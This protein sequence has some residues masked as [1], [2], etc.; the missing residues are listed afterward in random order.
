[1][2]AGVEKPGRPAGRG[3][4][5]RLHMWA[6][7]FGCCIGWGCFIMPGTEFL[8]EAGPAGTAIAMALGAAVMVLI[9]VNY[10]YMLNRY[11]DNGGAFTYT[12]KLFG[13]DQGF[14]CAWYLWL[15][16]VALI[17]AN[18]AAFILI[19]RQV[20]GNALA[21]GFHYRFAG[22]D[23]YFGE[24]LA[25]MGI[26]VLFGVASLYAGRLERMLHTVLALLL[27]A[28][29]VACF[30][31]VLARGGASGPIPAFSAARS[32]GRGV[33]H[34]VAL[35]PWAFIGFE[36]VSHVAG[37]DGFPRKS[38]LR[39]MAGA[40]IA[41]GVCYVLMVYV[42]ALRQPA[43]YSDW[44]G[45]IA[46]LGTKTGLAAIPT[47]FVVDS[48]LGKAGLA[49]LCVTVLAALST[50]M[51]GF[52]RVLGRLTGA[53][54]EDGILPAWF[55]RR[56]RSGNPRNAL[57]L[58]VL[59]S[60]PVPFL[61]ATA[62]G[63]FAD[64]T[65]I[66]AAISYSYTSAT[67]F[68][69]AR[70]TGDRRHALT[71]AAGTA[72]SVLFAVFLLMPKSAASSVQL[73]EESYLILSIWSVLGFVYFRF[74]FER[75]ANHSMNRSIVVWMVLLFLIF[76]PALM[77]TQQATRDNAQEAID[78]IAQ[79]YSQELADQGAA[80][81]AGWDARD[82][83]FLAERMSGVER[84]L[85][86]TTL[87][88]TLMILL[89]LYLL[90]SIYAEMRRREAQMEAEKAA[91]VAR[92]K[93][94]STFLSNMSHD[95]RTPMNAIVGYTTLAK[96]E[97]DMPPRIGD[98]LT[99]IESSSQHLLALI[100]DV[101]EM[102]RIETGE[103]DLELSETDLVRTMGEI[104]DMFQTQMETKRIRYLVE[105]E[106]VKDRRVLCDKN[107]LNRVLLNLL[108]NAYKF[109]PEGG[110]VSVRLRQTGALADRGSYEVRVR[111]SGIGMSPEFAA[112]VFEAYEREKT[113]GK[114]QGTGLGMAITKSIVDLMGG[115]ITVNTE[116]GKGS[117][118]VVAVDFALAGEAAAEDAAEEVAP[119]T[120]AETP[121]VD[122]STKKLLLV[123]DNEINREIATLILEEMG[124]GLDMAENGKIAVEKVMASKPGDYDAILMDIQMPVMNGYEAA[125][126]IRALENPALASI[127]IAAMTA[128]A[129]AE[130]IQA[131]EEAGMNGHIAKP[132]D[133]DD[134]FETL[135]KILR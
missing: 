115:T 53:L 26:L 126:A 22:Y 58:I 64:I 40:V 60:L 86:G 14:L 75:D 111:D 127:P 73:P 25:T 50:S 39:I 43:P 78:R 32:P 66:G 96:K 116:Q 114:I 81:Q 132:I 12:K 65:T 52:Y 106:G 87:V 1:M 130:D 121:A 129:F 103:M 54:G 23:V 95:I 70:R 19:A 17:W 117:E 98:Y 2:K 72:V 61:G 102:S 133:I 62:I 74:A 122:F 92:D 9:A 135:K 113:A 82:A 16:Y 42:A 63:W 104:R 18:S 11:P 29:V 7:A 37:E 131:A 101:L 83:A 99:K 57:L 67:V 3:S 94:K 107:R 10:H 123:E 119:E 69:D 77:W 124:F 35:A 80:R 120:A 110:T 27:L 30:L 68:W 21:F 41:A 118:F 44:Q 79:A 28:G 4:D 8:P 56:N 97:P 55:A 31:L 34:L 6:L 84:T 89:A 85:R 51:L 15:T 88:Q 108:S 76:F 134:M 109:T 13:A 125:R 112:R 20:L 46:A 71:G 33:F 38:A 100:N 5:S 128:N 45:Y 93:A 24:V 49:L 59:L 90:I 48:I 47:F 36:A 105:T 91:A